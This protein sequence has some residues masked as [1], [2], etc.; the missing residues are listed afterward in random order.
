M[1]P[2]TS[3]TAYLGGIEII[4]CTWSTIRWPSSIRLCF[5]SARRRNTSPRCC[6][7]SLYS[8]LRR[9]LGMKITW[10]LHSHLLWLKLSYSS[11]RDLLLVCLAAHD[12]EFLGWSVLQ[13]CTD[14]GVNMT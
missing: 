2:T 3:D 12:L 13:K 10:Y 7:S 6:R 5:C 1:K 9:H 11:I 4:M 14:E 8:V